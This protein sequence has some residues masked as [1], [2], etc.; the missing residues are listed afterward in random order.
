LQNDSSQKINGTSKADA[1][2]IKVRALR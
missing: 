1:S 2:M